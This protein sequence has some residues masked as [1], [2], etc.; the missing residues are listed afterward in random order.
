M[1]PFDV[2][3]AISRDILVNGF[4]P[5]F[6]GFKSSNE[7]TVSIPA[8]CAARELNTVIGLPVSNNAGISFPFIHNVTAGNIDPGND[9]NGTRV[10]P[11]RLKHS[12]FP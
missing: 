8:S 7:M 4:H 11:S 6:S 2:A 3:V 1:S 10:N 12:S 9:S 5:A